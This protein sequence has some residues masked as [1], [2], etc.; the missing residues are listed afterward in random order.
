MVRLEKVIERLRNTK[1]TA[2]FTDVKRAAEHFGYKL[3]RINGSHHVFVAEGRHSIV[4][5]VHNNTVK[6]VYVKKLFEEVGLV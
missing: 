1:G 5:P 3:D 2:R 6:M 4:I